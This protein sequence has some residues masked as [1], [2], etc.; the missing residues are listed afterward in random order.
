MNCGNTRPSVFICV[1]VAVKPAMRMYDVRLPDVHILNAAKNVLQADRVSNVNLSSENLHV[2]YF[3]F[4]FFKRAFGLWDWRC[5]C[6]GFRSR[7]S[8]DC[9]LRDNPQ[10]RC[11]CVAIKLVGRFVV[12]F[13][14]EGQ[15]A[16]FT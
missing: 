8:I 9:R 1:G 6:F 12:D 11:L 10:W 7:K 16:M 2:N 5:N 14:S 3:G 4:C 15:N 13:V